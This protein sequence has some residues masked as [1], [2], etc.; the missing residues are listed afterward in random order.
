MS[1][2]GINLPP[3]RPLPPDVRKRLRRRVVGGGAVRAP[4]AAAAAVVILAAGGA[5][6]AQST[7]GDDRTAVT[8]PSTT[9]SAAGSQAPPVTG[10]SPG[11]ATT[12]A[13]RCGLGDADVRF[14]LLLAGRRIL[15]TRDDRFCE[16]THT[17]ISKNSP[18]VGPVPLE[19]GAAAVL[20]R[21]GSGVL[22]GRVPAGTGHVVLDSG[23]PTGAGPVPVSLVED[24]FVTP[25]TTVGLSARF[26][27]ASSVVFAGIDVVALPTAEVWAAPREELPPGDPDVAR[28]LDRAL[29]DAA[30]WVGDPLKW[31][32]GAVSGQAADARL[33]LHD[34]A[35]KTALCEFSLGRPLLVHEEDP[36]PRRG[37]SFAIRHVTSRET[38]PG[39]GDGHVLLAGT[40]DA[41]RVGGLE[42]TDP[43]G[44]TVAATLRDGTFIARLDQRHLTATD[45]L[46]DGFRV[47]VLDHGNQP[48]ET[49][50]LG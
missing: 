38:G 17:T 1:Q 12:D 8:P 40:V 27:T 19:D 21:S 37:E 44:R 9:S 14:T 33:V 3:R 11:A 2:P 16:L 23:D 45:A 22:I 5:I 50:T 13:A 26:T 32:P 29:L 6:I 49:V 46:L 35:G 20:W 41:A 25:Y 18:A 39:P 15:V 43:R 10:V 24:L 30:R 7:G 4:L 42:I 28:C 34:Q 31:R 47:R 48:V 36:A